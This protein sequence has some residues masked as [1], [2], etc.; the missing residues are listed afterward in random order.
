[1]EQKCHSQIKAH[2]EKAYTERIGRRENERG[3]QSLRQTYSEEEVFTKILDKSIYQKARDKNNQKK[4]KKED[5]NEEETKS[6]YLV[7]ILKKLSLDVAGTDLDEEAAILVKNEALKNLKERLLTRAEIIQK[8]LA[9]EQKKLES[10]FAS[11][12]RKGEAMSKEDEEKYDN[13]IHK[14]NFRIDIL[15][16]RASQ[17]YRTSL[18]KFTELDDKLSQDPRLKNINNNGGKKAN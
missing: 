16:E 17:H 9:E 13:E 4:L 8:R 11:L 1:M 5:V 2:E 18:R 7:P 10:A 3:I 14:A 12:K 6:D 15:T